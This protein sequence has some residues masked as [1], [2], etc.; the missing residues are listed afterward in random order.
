MPQKVANVFIEKNSRCFL[1]DLCSENTFLTHNKKMIYIRIK[2]H[3]VILRLDRRIH[4][5]IF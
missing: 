2:N 5:T 1:A 4:E 3:M